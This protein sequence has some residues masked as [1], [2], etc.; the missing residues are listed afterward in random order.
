MV[1]CLPTYLCLGGLQVLNLF[2]LCPDVKNGY[3]RLDHRSQSAVVALAIY[4]LESRLNFPE[5]PVPH[6]DRILP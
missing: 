5:Q 1:A 4:Y 3:V 6:K 2:N